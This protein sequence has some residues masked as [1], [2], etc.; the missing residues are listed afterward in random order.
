MPETNDTALG[1]CRADGLSGTARQVHRAVLGTLARTGK[2]P[3]RPELERIA[4]NAGVS[5]DAVLAELAEADVMAFTA[6]GEIRAAY[7]F[8][9]VRTPIQVSWAGGPAAYAMCAIDALGMS[10]MLGRPVAITAAE[11]GTGRVITVRADGGRARWRPRTAVVFAGSAGDARRQSADRACGC[12][13]FFASARS[14]RAWARRHPEVTGRLLT[15]QGAL[16]IG[17]AEFGTLLQAAPR[18][19][20]PAATSPEEPA[21]LLRKDPAL[22]SA[23]LVAR[24]GGTGT[25]L[26]LVTD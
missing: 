4:R 7:P 3:A 18:A 15:R 14:A 8:S 23:R 12:I 9:P 6:G 17:I 2:P 1:G 16:D 21:E 13:N 20:A 22:A 26:H 5:L 25:P 10:A 11:P 19:S 24:D